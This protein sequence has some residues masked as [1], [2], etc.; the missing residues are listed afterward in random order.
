MKRSTILMFVMFAAM[1]M[2]VLL[3]PSTDRARGPHTVF[4]GA[5]A[6]ASP[7]AP[8]QQGQG[9]LMALLENLRREVAVLRDKVAAS[10]KAAAQPEPQP[11]PTPEE[12]ARQMEQW[13]EHMVVVAD[14]YA[15]EPADQAWAAQTSELIHAKAQGSQWLR[16]AVRGVECRSH[17]CRVELV[18]DGSGNVAKGVPIFVNQLGTALPLA[19]A[20]HG[21]DDSGQKTVTL[22]F[23]QLDS[24]VA[25]AQTT[26]PPAP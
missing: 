17:S 9:D 5:P 18:D 1:G 19:Q 20:D 7:A 8:V 6:Q 24:A 21:Q 14:A 26:T 2:Y 4:H 3:V 25:I 15:R 22:Y 16:S 11:P 23:T 10:E 12:A 13:R